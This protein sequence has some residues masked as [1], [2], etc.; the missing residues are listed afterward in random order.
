MPHLKD[1]PPAVLRDRHRLSIQQVNALLGEAVFTEIMGEKIK[2]L[3]IISEFIT[4]SDLLLGEG[5]DHIL[6]KGPELSY[7]LYGDASVRNYNDIDILVNIKHI[8][9]VINLIEKEGY[10]IAYVK[11]PGK[12]TLQRKLTSHINHIT[13]ISPGQGNLIEVH[14]RLLRTP[15]IGLLKFDNLI[16]SNLSIINFAG[17]SF[18]ILNN[19][20]ELLYIIMHG[21][22]HFWSRLKWLLDV[23]LFIKTNSIDW[24]KFMDLAKVLKAEKMVALY[25]EI[26]DDYFA[27]ESGIPC[28]FRIPRRTAQYCRKR[29]EDIGDTALGTL[30]SVLE[31]FF[32]TLFA[33]R[34]FHYK[35]QIIRSFVF[36]SFFSGRIKSIIH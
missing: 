22:L 15:P 17:R 20:I 2:E 11:W 26:H 16:S 3:E 24:H 34:G 28:N 5:I 32:Y 8:N 7:R 29:I 19:E 30:K 12:R 31:N 35:M 9:H 14:W 18:R 1:I 4:V 25:Q 27:H 33:F 21:G 23:D 13:F 36:M 10:R 6:L